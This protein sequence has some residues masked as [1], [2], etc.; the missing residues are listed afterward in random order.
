M[1]VHLK[2]SSSTVK[3][4]VA[5]GWKRPLIVALGEDDFDVG[6]HEGNEKG[7]SGEKGSVREWY[8]YSNA[9]KHRNLRNFPSPFV[10]GTYDGNN[11]E[12][13]D[14]FRRVRS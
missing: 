2:D 13:A 14:R 6:R 8:T 4:E 1:E 3:T 11:E 9:Q 7:F 12:A 10:A 5:S